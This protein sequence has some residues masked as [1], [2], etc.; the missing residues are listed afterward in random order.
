MSS[1]N[2]A[3]QIQT[4]SVGRLR[5]IPFDALSVLEIL[6]AHVMHLLKQNKM[7]RNI[8]SARTNISL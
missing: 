3:S 8:I 2:E 4:S 1:L 7:N 6:D 5:N